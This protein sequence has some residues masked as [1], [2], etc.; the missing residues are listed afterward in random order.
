MKKTKIK[1]VFLVG[2][3]EHN[4]MLE[5]EYFYTLSDKAILDSLYERGKTV[6]IG[7]N[8]YHIVNDGQIHYLRYE[9]AP[10]TIYEP[11]WY[12]NLF[13]RLAGVSSR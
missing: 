10:V 7:D 5:Q 13:L 4:I 6:W 12:N 9:V 1:R 2:K 8:L 3:G 11:S